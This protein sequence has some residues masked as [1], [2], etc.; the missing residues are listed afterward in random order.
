VG[1]VVAVRRFQQGLA[2]FFA[3]LAVVQPI[4]SVLVLAGG[5]FPKTACAFRDY[6]DGLLST[7]AFAIEGALLLDGLTEAA[8]HEFATD[9]KLDLL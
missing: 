3:L 4:S 1:D 7:F 6:L 5:R 9:I 8:L 2:A